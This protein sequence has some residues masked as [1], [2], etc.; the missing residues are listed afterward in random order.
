MKD[1]VDVFPYD[2]INETGTYNYDTNGRLISREEDSG[3]NG[4]IDATGTFTYDTHGNLGTEE[5]DINNDG[6]V[7]ERYVHTW[8]K[9]M[10]WIGGMDN[11]IPDLKILGLICN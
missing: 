1:E 7:D 2:T 3:N 9:G 4:T 6:T 8:E 10:C 5:Y 11:S